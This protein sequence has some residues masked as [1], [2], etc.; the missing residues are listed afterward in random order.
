M[1]E[2]WDLFDENNVPT[3]ESLRRGERIPKGRY[4]RVVEA[5]VRTPSGYYIL[6]KRS[7]KKRNYPGYWSCTACGSV[8][9]GEAPD[10]AMI[11]EMK[12][13]MGIEL[14][15]DELVLDRILTEFPAHYYIYR[16]EKELSEED[17]TL[18]PEEVD[19]FVFLKQDDMIEWMETKRMTKLSY[20]K[21]FFERWT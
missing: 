12:E 15:E 16:I 19:D 17:I 14:T 18:D 13:E 4:H 8:V 6:Q 9:K 10:A 1:S 5:W 11:R 3:Q 20:Y 7:M 2:Y 21:D